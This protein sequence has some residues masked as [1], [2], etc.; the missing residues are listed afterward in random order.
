MPTLSEF[1][2]L[3]DLKRVHSSLNTFLNTHD[4]AILC[5]WARRV[6]DRGYVAGVRAPLVTKVALNLPITEDKET[7]PKNG[8]A[9]NF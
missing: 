3:A 7:A 9:W 4:L 8:R 1:D 2:P 5:A 6:Y